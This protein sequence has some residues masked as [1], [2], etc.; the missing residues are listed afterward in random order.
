MSHRHVRPIALLLTLVLL[1]NLLPRPVAADAPA[2]V[3]VR[4]VAGADPVQVAQDYGATLVAEIPTLEIYRLEGSSPTLLTDLQADPRV[5]SAEDEQLLEGQPRFTDASGYELLEAQR[6]TIG[7]GGEATDAELYAE[8]W[9]VAKIRA[10]QAHTVV[11][12]TGVVVAVLDTGL[13]LDH[14]LLAERL[15]AGYDCVDDDADPAELPNG[16]DD[17]GDGVVDE[18]SGHGTHVAGIV[19]L[20]APGAILMPVRIF[21]S[22]GNGSYFNAAAGIVY[23]V[24]HG[25]DVINL[26]GSGAVET[27]ALGAAIQ[28]AHDHGVIVVAAGGVNALGY[29]AGYSGVIAVGASDAHDYTTDFSRFTDGQATV[30]APGTAIFSAHYDGGYA[31]WTGN[32]MAAPLVAGEAALLLATGACSSDCARTLISEH[33]RDLADTDLAGTRIDLYDAVSAAAGAVDVDLSLRYANGDSG[34]DDDNRI[35]PVV[36]IV[37]HGTSIALDTLTLRYWYTDEG[38]ETPTFACDYAP[39]GAANVTG[40]FGTIAAVDGA[41]HYLEVGFTE[42]AGKVFGGSSSGDLRLRFQ[43]SAESSYDEL[44]DYSYDPGKTELTEWERITLYHEGTLIW[45]T[46]PGDVVPTATGLK[47]QYLADDTDATNATVAPWLQL[48][49]SSAESVPYEELTLRYW[50]NGESQPDVYHCDYALVDCANVTGSFTSLSEARDG[51]NAYLELGFTPGAGAL[52]AFASSGKI[53]SRFHHEDWSNHDESDD[54]A[55][56][57]SKTAFADWERVTLYRNGALIWGTEPEILST[58]DPDPSPAPASSTVPLKAQYQAGNTHAGD[59]QVQPWLQVINRGDSAVALSAVTLRY[60]YTNEGQCPQQLHCD[61]AALGCDN[62]AGNFGQTT[63]AGGAVVDYLEVS[64]SVDAGSLAA[65][66]GSGSIQLRFHKDDWSNYD[67]S[68][69]YTFDPTKTTLS[70]WERVSLYLDGQLIWG[71]EP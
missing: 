57:P 43:M 42:G 7:M 68:D 63:D 40:A 25:A 26:S 47:V 18:G 44:G 12:G 32:S 66:A 36:E 58:G 45:G 53:Q 59:N 60:W 56:D 5:L 6:R 33:V 31:W 29:P 67:E 52:P 35:M 41:D 69:D 62:V 38:P 65:G 13:D 54:Y 11:T 21:D 64:F 71:V 61:Y 30:F 49:N 70:D 19:A 9:A 17:D 2:G 10:P 34:T 15:M 27:P 1:M 46:E 28:Y 37:N 4:L 23:A 22:E 39:F 3:I 24:D 51:A 48:V 20:V 16:V 50:Y 55:F 8:Q 14:P